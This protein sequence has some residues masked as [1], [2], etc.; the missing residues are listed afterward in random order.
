MAAEFEEQHPIPQ[1]IS[2]YQFR[3][4]GDMTLKQFLQV[5]AGALIALLLYSSP[6]HPAIKW[7]LTIFSLLM[8]IALA[9]LPLEDR[10]LGTWI[11]AFFRSI[12]SPTIF[13]WKRPVKPL[14]FFKSEEAPAAVEM[15]KPVVKEVEPT[16]E[17]TSGTIFISE[18]ESKVL[19]KLEEKEKSFL[20]R[21]TELFRITPVKPAVEGPDV[22]QQGVVTPEPIT[23]TVVPEEEKV[24]TTP[25]EQVD[26]QPQ[27]TDVVDMTTKIIPTVYEKPTPGQKPAA[28]AHDASKLAPPTQENIVIGEVLDTEGKIVEG[29][30]LEIKDEEGRP[31]RAFKTNKLGFFRIV[32]PLFN[33]KYEIITEKEGLVF[34]PV[35]I[36][37]EG[38]I[39]QPISIKAKE[40]EGGN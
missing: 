2:S 27:D 15:P 18:E 3:L 12:Y 40:K 37:A 19:T 26:T 11:I 38:K 25:N 14:Q 31:V 10:P 36:I 1:D 21:I 30:I 29:A 6:L 35:T 16:E 23:V 5:A 24:L 39:I 28:Q 32:T 22:K 34:D 4:V 9:F 7:P 13:V 8:G 17:V 20:A 33:G